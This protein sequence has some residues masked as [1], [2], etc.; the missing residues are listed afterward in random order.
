MVV[1]M[2][3]FRGLVMVEVAVAPEKDVT[4]MVMVF[5]RDRCGRGSQAQAGEC[6]EDE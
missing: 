3:R 6:N 1:V 4:V 5:R 2:V